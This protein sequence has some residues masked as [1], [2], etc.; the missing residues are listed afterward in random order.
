[1]C[2][3]TALLMQGNKQSYSIAWKK[4]VVKYKCH[5]TNDY[6]NKPSNIRYH[7]ICTCT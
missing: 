2:T 6:I 1:M 7:Y 3:P 5:C 4:I